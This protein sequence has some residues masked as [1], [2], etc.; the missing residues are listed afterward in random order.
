MV[1]M[2]VKSL[3][4]FF[5]KGLKLFLLINVTSS[6]AITER[7]R[8]RVDFSISYGQSGRLELGDNIYGYYKSIFNHCDLFGQQSN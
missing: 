2:Q 6:S 1:L 5:V 4:I 7:P 3:V 8:C